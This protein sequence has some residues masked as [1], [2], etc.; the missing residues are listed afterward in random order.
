MRSPSSSESVSLRDR[1]RLGTE[2]FRRGTDSVGDLGPMRRKT[3]WDVDWKRVLRDAK[4]CWASLGR[5]IRK[6]GGVGTRPT[7]SEDERSNRTWFLL[8]FWPFK[9]SWTLSNS[10]GWDK[11]QESWILGERLSSNQKSAPTLW[12]VDAIEEEEVKSQISPLRESD[13]FEW[14][15]ENRD[16]KR[17]CVVGPSLNSV[18]QETVSFLTPFQKAQNSSPVTDGDDAGAIGNDSLLRDSKARRRTVIWN[19][20]DDEEEDRGWMNSRSRGDESVRDE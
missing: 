2:E 10:L 18:G 1:E 15:T 17:D 16:L 4:D 12:D 19:A 13:V 20:S 3:G 11:K 9:N 6:G 5:R 7:S 8:L 14:W